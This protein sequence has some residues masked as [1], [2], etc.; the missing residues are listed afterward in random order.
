MI[1]Q[2]L[3]VSLHMAFVEARQQRHEFITVE[4]LLLALLDNPSAAEVLRACSANIDDLRKSLITFIKDNT[5]QVA[6]TEDVDTQPTLG[7][8]RVIQRAIMHVQSTGSGKKEV[9]G[10]NVLVAIFGEKDS[11]AVYYLHQQGVT[12]LDVVNFIAHGIKKS[13]P[14]E[15]VR[16]ADNPAES[17]EGA[18]EK[19]EKSS[20]LEQFTQNLN[21]LAKDGKIDPLIGRELE[22]E[23]VIQI[24]CRRRKNNP[25]LVGEAGVGKTAIAEG[26][27]WRITQKD[28]PEILADS[29]VYSLDM[30]ALLAGTKY[31]GDFEQ[32]LK[33]V[34]KSLKDKPNTI[35]FIDE[36]HTLIGA[37]AASGGTLDA[38]NLLKPALSS[39][40]LKCIGATTFTEY[41][42]IFEKDAALSR[43]FQKIDVLE[44]SVEQTVDILKGLKSRFEEHHHVKYALA[45]LQ[46]AAE[47]S[48][49]Y[50]NDR[51][52]PDKAIDVI[53]EAGAA[54][55]ILPPSKRKKIISKAE[56]EDI[57]AKIAR[58]PPANVSNDDRGKL[59]T[60]ERDL[61]NVVFGQ[62][63]ALD[64][65]ASAVKMSRSGLG[66][67]DKP[68]GTFLFSGPTGVGKTESAKQL[69]Y[70]MGIELIRFDMSEYMEQHAV[71][72]LIGAPPG[73]VGFDQ[74]G[75]LTEAITKKP[76]CV[77]LLDE[78]EKA[79]PA[80]FNVLLQVMDHG[81]LTDNNGRKADFRNV[82]I[83]MTTN[84]GAETMAKATIGF[85]NPREAGDEMADIKR[86]FTPEFRN[87]LDAIVSFKA[88][89]ENVILRV[90][91]KFLLQ[92]EAQ[93]ADKKVEV[94]FT[95][96]LRK[97]LAKKGF[98]PLMGA[99]PMQ[100]LIQDTIRRA[101]ADELLFG[102]LVDGG[103]LTVELD[104]TDESK[105]EVLLDIQPL[106]K[107]EGRSKPE[108]P[109]AA[110]T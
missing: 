95:D 49:K 3:E 82:I 59:K 61:R 7:F 85:T 48:A 20:P 50:I 88:L 27:A 45:A 79:H 92:L 6:G 17:D 9:T 71:S 106:P 81:T 86:M 39:G 5:P 52:L 66:K 94:T 21:Q 47:L 55:R 11:H 19:N 69:A 24:L 34:L 78:I 44:P 8:Q 4:H 53:D 35:L 67:G 105:T 73:Y 28:V 99:R 107:K 63:K 30:G 51:H 108:V 62:D 42:G 65:L 12:R 38:S 10:A 103:R 58:I 68:I 60:L 31:R 70:I 90:V 14:P 56:I 87:R 37:G 91:D 97:H 16:S 96:K 98:D 18:A 64:M 25:L 46:A 72:R 1:A 77:L 76:H 2:E 32:R 36:I 75:L 84:A 74:G 33:G 23:R 41:R 15:P 26:L 110:T 80:I 93:L 40:A 89:D 43:R 102:R 109:E 100:R 83:I 13:D 22:V 101:L 54:Q 104:D 57:V 29:I